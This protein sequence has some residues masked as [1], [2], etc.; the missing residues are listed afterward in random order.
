M[1]LHMYARRCWDWK[2][3]SVL[4]PVPY[5]YHHLLVV[6]Y[7]S[8]CHQMLSYAFHR[9]C[10]NMPAAGPQCIITL[11]HTHDRFT[12]LTAFPQSCL[13]GTPVLSSR[14]TSGELMPKLASGRRKWCSRCALLISASR[15][16]LGRA[17]WWMA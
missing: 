17:P 9:L 2:G 4:S 15:P 1:N 16:P 6:D 14:S 12:P 10:F 5:L 8:N 7:K 3:H 13:A 11:L